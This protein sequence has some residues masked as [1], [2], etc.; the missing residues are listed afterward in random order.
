[1]QCKNWQKDPAFNSGLRDELRL[2]KY[3]RKYADLT[4]E[5]LAG[6]L[7]LLGEY[8]AR[9]ERLLPLTQAVTYGARRKISAHD[10]LCSNRDYTLD[11]AKQLQREA[12]G[13]EGAVVHG[14]KI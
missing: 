3:T 11:A 8:T 10:A 7:W 9:A 4:G 12:A 1:M 14:L 2:G 13:P 5:Q 6:L